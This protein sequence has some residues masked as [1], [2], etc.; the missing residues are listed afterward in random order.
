MV[1]DLTG[2]LGTFSPKNQAISVT[3][4]QHGTPMIFRVIPSNPV[5]HVGLN[6][7]H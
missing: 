4:A 6:G 3:A 1:R 5:I 2:P 7:Y